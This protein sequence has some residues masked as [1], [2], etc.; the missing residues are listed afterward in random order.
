MELVVWCLN[1]TWES[2]QPIA[3]MLSVKVV[4]YSAILGF[5]FGIKIG[6]LSCSP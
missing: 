1:L 2:D 4:R 6:V 3:R 5:R